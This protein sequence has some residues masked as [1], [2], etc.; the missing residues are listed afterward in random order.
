MMVPWKVSA[1]AALWLSATAVGANLEQ[2]TS[3]GAAVFT[4][5]VYPRILVPRQEQ[6]IPADDRNPPPPIVPNPQPNQPGGPNTPVPAPEPE[7]TAEPNN[8]PPP[9]T[10][11]AAPE[12]EITT[13]PEN[14]PAPVTTQKPDEPED[15]KT[16]DG[17]PVP[18]PQIYS[19]VYVTCPVPIDCPAKQT[20]TI[21]T[22]IFPEESVLFGEVPA[23]NEAIPTMEAI[24]DDTS[25]YFQQVFDDENISINDAQHP[26]VQCQQQSNDDVPR[27]CF[28]SIYFKFCADV[29][30]HEGD[31][32]SKNLTGADAES[33]SQEK[34]ASLNLRRHMLRERA[35]SCEGWVFEY[36]WSGAKGDCQIPCGDSMYAFGDE[37]F[38]SE[39][40]FL[41][42]T[43]DVGCG[44]YK[45]T[46]MPT[47]STTAP[48]FHLTGLPTLTDVPGPISTPDGSS[49]A[50][51]ATNTQCAQGGGGR[52]Q[53]CVEN[54]YC[55]SWVSTK[56]TEAPS[57]PEEKIT[58]LELG[59]VFCKNRGGDHKDVSP[60]AVK[61]LADAYCEAN[62]PVDMKS[63][64]PAA[65]ITKSD[66]YYYEVS[67]VEGC[68][69]TVES[70]DPYIPLG[71]DGPLCKDLFVKAYAGCDNGGIG[72]YIDAGCVRYMFLGAQ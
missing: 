70:Q 46:A 44:T 16:T 19:T 65:G 55:A 30:G 33:G 5:P 42:G 56:P 59:P 22:S 39:N 63:D 35:E 11:I 64:S 48:P 54:T 27:D 25:R 28:M 15:P 58:P 21:T 17:A 36:D 62:L 13:E 50:E 61:S 51:T 24:E 29:N 23:D 6:E 14:P 2:E 1:I 9:A 32:L 43:I 60:G 7:T 18:V 3:S 49:C 47:T 8:P 52:G 45:Y 40:S 34:R 41:E 66:L 4:H 31:E 68:K 12:P 53:A 72:G 20:P 10:T 38:D 26:D 37:C 67:W 57:P 69:T 71:N